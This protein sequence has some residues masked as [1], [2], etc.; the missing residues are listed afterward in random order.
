M[1]TLFFGV[2]HSSH[3]EAVHIPLIQIAYRKKTDLEVKAFLDD[4]PEFTHLVFTSKHGVQAL[5]QLITADEIREKVIISI[6]A[7]T[8]AALTS[9]G[10]RVQH[11]AKEETQEGVLH[12]L[13]LLD[14]R[15]AYIGIPC[16]SRARGLLPTLLA[17]RGVRHLIG[18]LY[19][20]ILIEDAALPD[21]DSVKEIIFSSPSTVDAFKKYTDSFPR[22][23]SVQFQGAITKQRFEE[24]F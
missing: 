7:K 2:D 11:T 23:L 18:H 4:V 21:L 6:G 10:I 22:H 12:E 3:P 15:N 17:Y 13:N 9:F 14:L 20:T 5:M 16:S 8:T 1:S 24:I 19:D